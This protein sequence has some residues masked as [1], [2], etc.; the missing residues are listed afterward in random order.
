MPDGFTLTNLVSDPGFETS[1]AKFA[2]FSRSEGS[3]ART[4]T[5]PIAGKASLKVH[6]NAFGRVGLVHNYPWDGGPIGDS[7]TVAGKIR[8]DGA[9]A[10]R[11]LQVCAIA[12]FFLDQEPQQTCR[13]LSVSGPRSRPCS[14]PNPRSAASWTARS[15]SSTSTTA[16][17]STRRSTTPTLRGGEVAQSSQSGAKPGSRMRPSFGSP[18]IASR[19]SSVSSK[20]KTSKFSSRRSWLGGLRDGGDVG[21]VEQPA[22]RDLAGGLAVPLADLPQRLLVQDL[23]AGERRVGGDHQVLLGQRHQ[24]VLAQQR[25]ELDLVGEVGVTPVPPEHAGGEVRDAEVLGQP[26]RDSSAS[27]PI[28]SS[29]GTASLG[30]CSSNRST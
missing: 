17:A 10:G 15:S 22:Q 12:Y 1:A 18:S 6:V 28:V 9:S 19:S 3:V 24:L 30:Q 7:V 5:N 11:V 4:T 14:S 26:R 29:S 20:S 16:A 23:A 13:D 27:A 25:V 21:L 2:A 8:I